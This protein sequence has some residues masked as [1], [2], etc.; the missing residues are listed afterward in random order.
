MTTAD[1]AGIAHLLC[2]AVRVLFTD[3]EI[4][5]VEDPVRPGLKVLGKK[6]LVADAA[7]AFVS[8]TSSRAMFASLHAEVPLP[9]FLQ[10][11]ALLRERPREQHIGLV[12]PLKRSFIRG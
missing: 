5:E 8:G 1:D 9:P 7:S 3:A 6:K 4:G 2:D 12:V 10:P 11:L